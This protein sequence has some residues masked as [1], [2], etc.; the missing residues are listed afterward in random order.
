M[1]RPAAGGAGAE[2]AGSRRSPCSCS[3]A[4]SARWTSSMNANAVV[5]RAEARRAPSCR[6]RTASGA[7]AASSAAALGGIVIQ[8]YG[9][10]A[11]ALLVTVVALAIAG[12]GARA[13]WSPT[14][15][16]W[17]R[18]TRSSRCRATR[19]IYLVGLMALLC[20]EFRRRGARLG[21]ALPAPGTRRRHRHRRLR[22][23]RSSPAPWR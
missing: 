3:A 13:I 10:L 22:L 8:N 18:S 7:S 2:R 9:H 14:T 20:D 16:R 19:P 1:L 23:R 6:P 15:T 5:G 4:R 11:H 21:G 17:R 12:A